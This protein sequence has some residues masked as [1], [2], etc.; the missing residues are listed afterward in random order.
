MEHAVGNSA[1]GAMAEEIEDDED[2]DDASGF[3]VL[4]HRPPAKRPRSVARDASKG[5]WRRRGVIEIV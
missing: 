2:E 1:A 4:T 5:A 3:G